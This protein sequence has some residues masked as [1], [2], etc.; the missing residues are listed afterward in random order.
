MKLDRV[1]KKFA[2]HLKNS[3]K[4]ER[5]GIVAMKIETARI[6]ILTFSLLTP[7]RRFR[8]WSGWGLSVATSLGHSY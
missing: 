1:L 7:R 3:L 5:G 2:R 6:H 8:E 4:I